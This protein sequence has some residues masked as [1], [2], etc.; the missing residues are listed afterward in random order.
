MLD[1]I[2]DVRAESWIKTKDTEV[3]IRMVTELYGELNVTV[4]LERSQDSYFLT[5]K[6]EQ[7]DRPPLFVTS[8]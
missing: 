7:P 2:D 1:K 6:A 8:S 5:C 3:S 4:S